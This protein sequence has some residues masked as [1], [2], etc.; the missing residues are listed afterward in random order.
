M[1]I[2]YNVTGD[3]RKALVGAISEILNKPT[4]YLGAPTFSYRVGDCRIDRKGV[5]IFS[6][7]TSREEADNL[8]AALKNRGYGAAVDTAAADYQDLRMTERKELDLSRE[9]HDPPSENGMRAGDLPEPNGSDKLTI[10]MPLTGFTPEKLD[11]LFKL[12]NAKAAIIKAALGAE[13]LPIRLIEDKLRFPWFAMT[14]AVGEADA[15]A[16]FI[17]ALCETA[18]K[19]KCVTA[20]EKPVD[21]EKFAM[22]IFLVRLGLNGP[23]NKAVR[24][25]LLKNLTGNGSWKNGRPPKRTAETENANDAGETSPADSNDLAEIL[26]DA[27]LIHE[28]NTSFER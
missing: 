17:H 15:Y 7:G 27:R 21:N 13:D 18:K 4:E 5:L 16:R 8:T 26:A 10:D 19:Q 2:D 14:G 24:Q 20:K 1:S 11:N 23:E 6:A 3:R 25:I 22:R 28:I 9:R 12:V